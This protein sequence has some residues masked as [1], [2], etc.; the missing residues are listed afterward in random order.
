MDTAVKNFSNHKDQSGR[1]SI[2][3]CE[4]CLSLETAVPRARCTVSQS[5]LSAPAVDADGRHE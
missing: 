1:S 3:T 4:L 2:D 5:L